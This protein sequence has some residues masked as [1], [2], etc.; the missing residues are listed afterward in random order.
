MVNTASQ[1]KQL[2]LKVESE[3]ILQAMGKLDKHMT[4]LET[5]RDRAVFQYDRL[6]NFIPAL[7]ILKLLDG[8]LLQVNKYTASGFSVTPEDMHGKNQTEFWPKEQCDN[9]TK[10]DISVCGSET[11]KYGYTEKVQY[12]GEAHTFRTWKVPI[13]NGKPKPIGVMLF[14]ID[15]S[16]FCNLDNAEFG[17]P[18]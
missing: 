12:G 13:W 10:D 17:T 7:L 16:V 8:T 14:S 5:E 1:H 2:S 11:G 3:A 4:L 18:F 9:F 15:L 6:M